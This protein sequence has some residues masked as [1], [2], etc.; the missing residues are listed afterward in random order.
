[1]PMPYLTEDGRQPKDCFVTIRGP[2]AVV[3]KCEFC[4]HAETLPVN[5]I[6]TGSGYG[7]R[8]GNKARGRMIQHIKA[9]HADKFPTVTG[10]RR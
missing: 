1:M 8:E 6:M 7:F 9:E 4:E 10:R 3:R 5:T 2:I